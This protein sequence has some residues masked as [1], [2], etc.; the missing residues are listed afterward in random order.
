M[1]RAQSRRGGIDRER[2]AR[3]RCSTGRLASA[4]AQ[5][6]E[7]TRCEGDRARPCP[8]R[9]RGE[10]RCPGR[11][12]RGARSSR[13][14][15]ARE[16]RRPRREGEGA[17]PRRRD[18]PVRAVGGRLAR[19][20]GPVAPDGD[21]SGAA[22][23]GA[24]IDGRPP[25]GTERSAR[26]A[27]VDRPRSDRQ[28]REVQPRRRPCRHVQL[29]RHDSS[30][31]RRDGRGGSPAGRTLRGHHRSGVQPGRSAARELGLGRHRADLG[32]QH[33][34]AAARVR[35]LGRRE[36]RRF[37]SGGAAVSD[38]HQRRKGAHLEPRDRR[39]GRR[40]GRTW[41]RR[42]VLVRVR[43]VRTIRDHCVS[44]R[45]GHGLGHGQR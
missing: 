22:A 34:A 6:R 3:A 14:G 4:A 36:P 40:A 28:R 1:G 18:P 27:H 7:R 17:R 25:R 30:L 9:D 16:E 41:D 12:G 32:G 20:S 21:R 43:R 38:G 19:R 35:A 33:G 45:H 37:R 10:E 26:G 42:A 5:C 29:R 15:V 13:C 11:Q 8:R 24:A 44:R 2:R 39:D 31:G 23:T